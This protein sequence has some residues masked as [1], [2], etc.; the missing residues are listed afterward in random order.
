MNRAHNGFTLVELLVVI[1]IILLLAALIFTTAGTATRLANRAVCS[2][3]L[4]HL[5]TAMTHYASSHRGKL[6]YSNQHSGYWLW[7]VDNT[8]RDL[9]VEYGAARDAFYCPDGAFQNT[10]ELWH[11]SSNYTVTGYFFLISRT[12]TAQ[13]RLQAGNRFYGAIYEMS[14]PAVTPLVTDS[15]ISSGTNRETAQ[16][17]NV[18]GGWY[19]IHRTSHIQPVGSDG[20]E[21]RPKPIGTNILYGDGHVAWREWPHMRLRTSGHP[22]EWW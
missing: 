14:D 2:T 12:C 16:F 19:Y 22:N 20:D 11:F 13:G 10:D 3:N 6:P 7:D 8:R 17:M 18:K 4:R 9:I 5:A 1:F 21:T 15:T